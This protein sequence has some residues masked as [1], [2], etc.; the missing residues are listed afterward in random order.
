MQVLEVHTEGFDRK[1]PRAWRTLAW[2][3]ADL[4]LIVRCLFLFEALVGTFGLVLIEGGHE[5]CEHTLI[6]VGTVLW[7]GF[8]DM[9]MD[10]L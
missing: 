3:H 1:G 9:Q 8:S 10:S 2:T 7:T 5:L 4:C 6:A